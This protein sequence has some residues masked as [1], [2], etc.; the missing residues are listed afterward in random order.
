MRSGD[1]IAGRFEIDRQVAAGGMGRVYRAHDKLV[2]NDVAIKVVLDEEQ[3]PDPRFAREA[4]V[5]AEVAHPAVVRYVAH[6]DTPNGWPFLAMEWLDGEDLADRL[7]RRR[8]A[9]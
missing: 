3:D 4:V 5:L 6:G 8:S 7:R 2:G 1:V 9:T